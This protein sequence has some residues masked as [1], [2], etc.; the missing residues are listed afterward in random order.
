MTK[1][2]KPQ[3]KQTPST[4]KDEACYFRAEKPLLEAIDQKGRELQ[5]QLGVELN[6]SEVIRM[7][8]KKQLGM[9]AP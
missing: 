7:L 9:I 1:K 8:L 3:E 5:Q 4:T 6:R 2:Q